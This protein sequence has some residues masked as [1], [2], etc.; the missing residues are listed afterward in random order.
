MQKTHDE[1][2]ETQFLFHLHAIVCVTTRS[3]SPDSHSSQ[4]PTILVID[5][6]THPNLQNPMQLLSF[7]HPT[8]ACS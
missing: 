7:G 3:L 2:E 5:R 4:P 8:F 6:T 1:I